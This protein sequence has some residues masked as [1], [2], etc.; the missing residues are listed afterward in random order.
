MIAD[1]VAKEKK[2]EEETEIG[3]PQA[4]KEENQLPPP[5]LKLEK[6]ENGSA[7]TIES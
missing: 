3:F 1:C 2:M 7:A 6:E 4:C 5:D